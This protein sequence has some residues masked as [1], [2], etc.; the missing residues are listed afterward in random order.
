[1]ALDQMTT[2]APGSRRLRTPPD[3]SRPCYRARRLSRSHPAQTRSAAK[4]RC[5]ILE[6]LEILQSE[7]LDP[8]HET[9]L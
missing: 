7:M 8:C 2:G 6:S 3:S 4:G 5:E 9:R 1:M